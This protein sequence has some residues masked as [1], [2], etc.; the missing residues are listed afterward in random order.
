MFDAL[1]DDAISII[2]RWRPS[3]QYGKENQYRD[4]LMEVLRKKFNEQFSLSFG[5]RNRVK[6][7]SE[8]GRHLCDIAINEKRLGIE[9]K[10]DLKHLK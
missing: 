10:K 8:S 6:I 7:T 1:F 3:K 9:L 2:T 5:T 4:E